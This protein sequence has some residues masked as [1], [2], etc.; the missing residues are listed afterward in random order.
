MLHAGGHDLDAIGLGAVVTDELACFL[1]AGR[2]DGVGAADHRGLGADAMVVVFVVGL[3]ARERVERRDERKLEIVLQRVAGQAREPVVGVD[4]LDAVIEGDETLAHRGGELFDDVRQPV[5]G[6]DRCRA[7]LDMVDAE[8]R[9]DR[10]RLREAG[11]PRAREDLA[12]DSGPGQRRR[13]LAD[14]DVHAPAVAGT[15]LCQGRRVQ[16]ENGDAGHDLAQPVYPAADS[17]SPD[18]SSGTLTRVPSFSCR[19]AS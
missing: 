4:G 2:E 14:V 7:R 11:S 5:L 16:R 1:G 10:D 18:L 13:K 8:A 15:W 12:R 9:L 6:D 19:N 17:S 3:D